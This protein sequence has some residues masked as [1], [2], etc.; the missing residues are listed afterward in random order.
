MRS[1]FFYLPHFFGLTL[2]IGFGS[3]FYISYQFRPEPIEIVYDNI[4]LDENIESSREITISGAVKLPGKYQ[5]SPGSSIHDLV[6]LADGLT[7]EADLSGVNLAQLIESDNIYIP[8]KESITPTNSTPSIDQP[9]DDSHDSKININTAD[10]DQL[11]TLPGI[12]AKT[13]EKI[14]EYRQ[15]NKFKS[16]EELMEV[17]GIG[18]S[19]FS[20]I[21]ELIS[22]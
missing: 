14:V 7:N 21:K 22:I 4:F 13:A 16:I 10:I 3:Y 17:K 6:I 5:M 12:G 20:N 18:E 8:A 1:L 2:L 11:I 19:K 15:T 9:V